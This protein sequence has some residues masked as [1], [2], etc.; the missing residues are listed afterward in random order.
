MKDIP[1]QLAPCGVYCGACPSL[2][3]TCKGCASSDES[4]KRKSKWH[5]PIRI[6]C[7]EEKKLDFCANCDDF[8]CAKVNKKL[9]QSHP[10]ED[11]YHYRHELIQTAD[12]IR[13][14]SVDDY[15]QYQDKRWRCPDCGGI[16][17]FYHYMCGQCGKQVFI[18]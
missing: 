3:K 1:R 2:D 9:I 14:L 15:H 18:K 16:V 5:C 4:Q 7:Y 12:K 13:E 6:C 8:F 11:K 17:C 10:G